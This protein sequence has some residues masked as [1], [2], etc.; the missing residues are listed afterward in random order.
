MNSHDTP[1]E[2]IR[3]ILAADKARSTREKLCHEGNHKWI[4]AYGHPYGEKY[5]DRC[6]IPYLLFKKRR[7]EAKP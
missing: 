1:L 3:R 5:C 7:E 6:G 2:E 4:R